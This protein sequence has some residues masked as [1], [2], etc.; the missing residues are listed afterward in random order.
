M[1][2]PRWR[3]A[4]ACRRALHQLSLSIFY[5]NYFASFL[6]FISSRLTVNDVLE[7]VSHQEEKAGGPHGHRKEK[8]TQRALYINIESCVWSG[9]NTQ[10]R[11]DGSCTIR[12]RPVS[13]VPLT[14][15]RLHHLASVARRTLCLILIPPIIL[16]IFHR[17][18]ISCRSGEKE[19]RADTNDTIPSSTFNIKLELNFHQL[20]SSR[21]LFVE[22][23]ATTALGL[24]LWASVDI[25]RPIIE[26]YINARFSGE[27]EEGDGRRDWR[28]FIDRR[29]GRWDKQK[30][31]KRKII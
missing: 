28:T 26:Q 14:T 7:S 2:R 6:S 22:Q 19:K 30:R 9:P 20:V 11:T 13:C 23:E 5:T 27:Q 12:I 24:Q 1:R 16:V 17:I 18:A 21:S 15:G 10:Q 25:A 31:K 3:I 29:W 4:G 8:Y